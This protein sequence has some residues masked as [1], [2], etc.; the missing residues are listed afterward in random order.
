[1]ILVVFPHQHMEHSQRAVLALAV[2]S[3]VEVKQVGVKEVADLGRGAILR[4]SGEVVLSLSLAEGG[5]ERCIEWAGGEDTRLEESVVTFV[6]K[7]SVDSSVVEV[8]NIAETSRYFEGLIHVTVGT[9]DGN[10]KLVAPLSMETISRCRFSK[11]TIK[12]TQSYWRWTTRLD[13][14]RIRTFVVVSIC[15]LQSA[16]RSF[17]LMIVVEVGLGQADAGSRLGS[18]SK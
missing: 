4:S 17:T 7:R 13:L 3:S 15:S 12:L 18:L 8:L 5:T 16:T 1:M 10:L 6:I 14:P 11:K 2:G 9:S